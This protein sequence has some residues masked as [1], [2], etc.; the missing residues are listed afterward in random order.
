MHYYQNVPTLNIFWRYRFNAALQ[1]LFSICVLILT[2]LYS[3]TA[4]A[5]I[6]FNPFSSVQMNAVI[7]PPERIGYFSATTLLDSL[8]MRQPH[9]P[10]SPPPFPSLVQ[11][12]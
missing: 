8:C 3:H 9:P 11:E 4:G 7:S 5:E 1:Y 10:P 2:F 12:V 6:K